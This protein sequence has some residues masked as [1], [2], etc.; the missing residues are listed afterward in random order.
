MVIPVALF[1]RLVQF[2]KDDFI[3]RAYHLC[4]LGEA[5]GRRGLYLVWKL[6]VIPYLQFSTTTHSCSSVQWH[7]DSLQR[8]NLQ[9]S[10]GIRIWNCVFSFQPYLSYFQFLPTSSIC[11]DLQC[12]L[13]IQ[14]SPVLAYNSAFSVE[15]KG[16][17]SVRS[18]I[19]YQT[20]S[21]FIRYPASKIWAP[22]FF[23]LFCLSFLS[24][25]FLLPLW[26]N[27]FKPRSLNH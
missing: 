25:P 9:P 19:I 17:K 5:E 21:T 8:I 27:V 13:A 24:F 20:R 11:G 22:L 7:S 6:P 16:L 12:K 10:F 4:L 1:F 14:L 3:S 18:F 15:R 23:V 26:V 2:L